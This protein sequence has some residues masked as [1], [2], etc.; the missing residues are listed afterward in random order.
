MMR[1]RQTD[2]PTAEAGHEIDGLRRRH[3]GGDD[4]IAL[5][6]P[7]LVVDQDEHAPVAGVLDHVLDIREKVRMDHRGIPSPSGPALSRRFT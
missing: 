4:E 3:L 6:L 5:V 2:Q 1:E 7:V